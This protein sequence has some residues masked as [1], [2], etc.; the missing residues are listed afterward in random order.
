LVVAHTRSRSEKCRP[1]SVAFDP[2]WQ[3]QHRIAW[4]RSGLENESTPAAYAAWRSKC[5]ERAFSLN[6]PA[7]AYLPSGTGSS[8]MFTK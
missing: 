4:D 5:R 2:A 7:T 3:T 6:A 8:P 1:L